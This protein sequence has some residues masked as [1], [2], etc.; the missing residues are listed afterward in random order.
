[1]SF[2]LHSSNRLERLADRLAACMSVQ[3]HNPFV[4]EPVIVQH[5]GLGRWLQ[6]ELARRLGACVNVQFQ[7]PRAFMG[8]LVDSL[9]A[10]NPAT[11]AYD[12][13][14]LEWHIYRLLSDLAPTESMS[15]P[16]LYLADG[17]PAKRAQLAAQ[18]ANLFDQ[19]LVY[20]PD[21]IDRWSN[22]D[23]SNWQAEIWCRLR[24]Q[25]NADPPS[26]RRRAAMEALH[27]GKSPFPS[28]RAPARIVLF[29]VSSLPPA[30]LELF[31][32]ISQ[33][34][35][36]H[37]FVL[38]PC[39][40]WW[41]DIVT[42][43][44]MDR[45]LRRMR[46]R[47]DDSIPLHFESGHR[48]LAAW[49]SQGRDFL[50]L[51][52]EQTQLEEY[53]DF[54]DP[55]D[56][57]LLNQ[58][59]RN[60]LFLNSSPSEEGADPPSIAVEDDSLQ[61]HSCH[62]PFR[63]LEVLQDRILDWLQRDPSL[64]PRDIVVMAPDISIYAPLVPAI[65]E[66]P[67]S[68]TRRIPYSIADRHPRAGRGVI[69]AFV[70]ILEMADT[71]LQVSDVLDLLEFPP[72]RDRVGI[73]EA[74]L[75]PIAGWV[76]DLNIQFGRDP[77][78]VQTLGLPLVVARTWRQGVDRLL[79]GQA[80]SD[81]ESGLL[82]APNGA[83]IAPLD[84][85][86]G[87]SADLAGCL[88][89]FVDGL[90]STLEEWDSSHSPNDWISQL[91]K[92]V[93]RLFLSSDDW[94]DSIVKLRQSIA[95][96]GK[97][98]VQAGPEERLP[99]RAILP[100]L[101]NELDV[102]TAAI[103]FLTG[104][105]TFC[106]LKPL[107][108]LP[109]K[110]ICLLGLNDGAFPRQAALPGFDLMQASPRLG[111]RSARTD[112]R[113]LF[114]ET[115]IS[116]RQWLHMSFV[117]QVAK[118]SSTLPPSPVVQQL[119][120]DLE[121]SFSLQDPKP[122]RRTTSPWII[123]HRLHGFATDY[124]SPESARPGARYFGYSNILAA[125]SH[126]GQRVRSAQKPFLPPE[127]IPQTSLPK[128]IESTQLAR[129]FADPI[130]A[131]F[132]HGLQLELPFDRHASGDE[133]GLDL[134]AGERIKLMDSLSRLIL[135]GQSW[136]STAPWL[137]ATGIL[138]PGSLG[139]WIL[140]KMGPEAEAYAERLRKYMDPAAPSRTVAFEVPMNSCSV[141]GVLQLGRHGCWLLRTRRGE[142]GPEFLTFWVHWLAAVASKV[143]GLG[144][145]ILA[146]P[147]NLW[148]WSRPAN[149]HE[150]LE[151][152]IQLYHQG[153]QR[154]LRYFPKASW[155]WWQTFQGQETKRSSA[156]S[157]ALKAWQGDI[158]S[159]HPPESEEPWIRRLT[160]HETDPLDAEFERLAEL[161][162]RPLFEHRSKL[163][164]SLEKS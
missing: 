13:G 95:E 116:A 105:I 68:P 74:D 143:E 138:P 85:I 75:P 22:G 106:D 1:M 10:D 5:V 59:Q 90:C 15:Q 129:F 156:R 30:Y 7:L 57:N 53:A 135:G 81:V 132:R 58:L 49:G 77:A 122:A 72:L 145:G 137:S 17:D 26:Q 146:A 99:L 124:F 110:V 64:V 62:S 65:L 93:N 157:A 11:T 160:G 134:T 8:Q 161:I 25:L 23:T 45:E 6:L 114:L 66:S 31:V 55:G 63:E 50:R 32:A 123:S 118:D 109:F 69:A 139:E 87:E 40:E 149:S 162:L 61:I 107:R 108:C 82:L 133:W 112:D 41:G 126:A 79:A 94:S 117:G 104:G 88:A 151:Q 84:G 9:A 44:E 86:E 38:Q 164:W 76:E 92:A 150:I 78:H 158:F 60:I 54:V 2:H 52:Q 43:R 28:D 4:S 80:I 115:V 89:E 141:R 24:S 127:P 42:P 130:K 70:R 16:R 3:S 96:W 142:Y 34:V 144:E 148:T 67:E 159:N 71:R 51:C 154:P 125:A 35:N 98:I 73:R 33:S 111:D 100:S 46:R 48:L 83:E 113:Y 152:L 97:K 47:A 12:R 91:Q 101:L 103:G 128:L 155:A 102:E 20:R 119:I 27:L 131:F 163:K 140:T 136:K 36:V 14:A 121:S 153:L 21:W 29:G 120:D 56:H 37:A 19:Y 147:G 39:A 18:L